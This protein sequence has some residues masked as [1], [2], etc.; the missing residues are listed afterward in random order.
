MPGLPQCP[1][2]K[3]GFRICAPFVL[4]CRCRICSVKSQQQEQKK[5][6]HRYHGTEAAVRRTLGPWAC[7]EPVRASRQNRRLFWSRSF[8]SRKKQTGGDSQR[9]SVVTLWPVVSCHRNE[10]FRAHIWSCKGSEKEVAVFMFHNV[11]IFRFLLWCNQF[12]DFWLFFRRCS[13][14]NL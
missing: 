8:C 14:L 13:S 5:N 2:P 12:S 4:G 9:C 6:S 7:S 10:F 3:F 1:L 11:S